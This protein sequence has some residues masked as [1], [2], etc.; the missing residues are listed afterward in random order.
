M[1]SFCGESAPCLIYINYDAF[2]GRGTNMFA[3]LE[4]YEVGNSFRERVKRRFRKP[5]ISIDRL[6]IYDGMHYYAIKAPVI[7]GEIDW[8]GIREAAGGCQQNA[9]SRKSAAARRCGLSQIQ[10]DG[11]PAHNPV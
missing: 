9:D 8:Q 7:D 3:V 6:S 1:M 5:D 11:I 10:T 4:L 2:C